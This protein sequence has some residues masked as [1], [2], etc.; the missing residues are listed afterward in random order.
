MKKQVQSYCSSSILFDMINTEKEL[1]KGHSD[2]A[3]VFL[4]PDLFGCFERENEIVTWL[5]IT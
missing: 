3:T 5:L 1:R 2:G 4:N